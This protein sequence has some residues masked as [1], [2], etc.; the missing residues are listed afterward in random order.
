MRDTVVYVHALLGLI[1]FCI[2]LL[3]FVLKRGGKNHRRLGRVYFFS[4]IGLL[5][6]GAYIGDLFITIIGLF[7]F[8]YVFTGFRFAVLKEKP[9]KWYDKSFML[10]GL[11][12]SLILL[13]YAVKLYLVGNL[14]FAIISLVFGLLFGL[15]TTQDVSRYILEKPIQK[16]NFGKMDWFFNH[17]AR[18]IVSYI[19]AL[20]AFTSIQDVFGNIALNFLVPVLFGTAYMVYT[21]KKYIREFKL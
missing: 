12:F 6:S 18:M 3:Q 7:G 8:Y 1:V 2:G 4:W 11:L 15:S 5:C 20:S 16:K 9:M 13:Y 14:N 17:S 19:A 21:E 10:A